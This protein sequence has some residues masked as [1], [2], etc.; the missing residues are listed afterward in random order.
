MRRLRL[1]LRR[2]VYSFGA[3]SSTVKAD[4]GLRLRSGSALE[5]L[6]LW[7]D[8][9]SRLPL[10]RSHEFGRLDLRCPSLLPPEEFLCSVAS[11]RLL[12]DSL[13]RL[14]LALRSPTLPLLFRDPRDDKLRLLLV[15][16]LEP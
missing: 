8:L 12:K 2:T 16:L 3:S 4:G 13:L 1:L 11:L 14:R 9:C 15:L 6:D 7:L 10:N 5:F